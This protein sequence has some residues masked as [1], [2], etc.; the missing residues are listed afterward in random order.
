[1]GAVVE[2][3]VTIE[4]KSLWFPTRASGERSFTM[5][6]EYGLNQI[7]KDRSL[8]IAEI[9]WSTG[10]VE[11]AFSLLPPTIP[12]GTRQKLRELLQPWPKGRYTEAYSRSG[13]ILN[14]FTPP[15]GEEQDE[16][17]AGMLSEWEDESFPDEQV[18]QKALRE[19]EQEWNTTS[20]PFFA[21]LSPA[22]VMV[23]GGPI[24]RELANQFLDHIAEMLDG[25]GFESEGEMLIQVVILL[26]GWQCQT[27]EDGQTIG[28]AIF[29]EREELLAR[30]ARILGQS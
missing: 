4:L 19:L 27:T 29:A 25:R 21:G 2:D 20:H 17:W 13:G 16:V 15:W 6:L 18:R 11:E 14:L 23:G 1:V 24:E 3:R 5:Q 12:A 9:A 10:D 26:R 30:R 28:D 22:Q 7:A 8:T